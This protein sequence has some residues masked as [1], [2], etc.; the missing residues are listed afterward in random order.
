M[1]PVHDV[2]IVGAG[3]LG[4]A[5]GRALAARG[6]DV[7]VL[8]QA[9][10]GHAGSGSKGSTRIFRMGYPDPDYVGAAR[11]ARDRWHELEAESGRHIL[12]PVPQLTFGAG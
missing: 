12:R 6:R 7:V 11:Q 3:L 2:A 8:E 4:L 1:T 5:T 10:V 9:E